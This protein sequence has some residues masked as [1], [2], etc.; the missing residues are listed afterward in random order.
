MLF[1]N[2]RPISELLCFSKILEKLMYKR[3]VD[4]IN[5]HD[6]LTSRQYGFRS[7]HSTNHAIIEVVDKI[8]KAIENNEFTVGIFLG[9][10]KAF[11]TIEET[12]FQWYTWQM[13]FMDR[14]L[15]FQKKADC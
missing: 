8:T 10:S 14:G 9:L 11:D 5:K 15:P 3:L 1:S 6:I 12:L 7:K 2:Y 13:S 4:Y